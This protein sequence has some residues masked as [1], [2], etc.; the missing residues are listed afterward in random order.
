[1]VV[2]GLRVKING[3][4]SSIYPGLASGD[5]ITLVTSGFSL[6]VELG[7]FC[8]ANPTRGTLP[9]ECSTK[10]FGKQSWRQSLKWR[11]LS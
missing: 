9:A 2:L 3:A 5:V 8:C 4:S 11:D 6:P 1:M 10:G 7:L